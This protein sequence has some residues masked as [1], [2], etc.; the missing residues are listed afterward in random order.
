MLSSLNKARNLLQWTAQPLVG[1][2]F[3]VEGGFA[4]PVQSAKGL[5]SPMPCRI[6]VPGVGLHLRPTCLK[7]LARRVWFSKTR[8]GFA[9]AFMNQKQ[10][11]TN[12]MPEGKRLQNAP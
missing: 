12:T 7:C 5:A 3:A 4:K 6:V 1:V 8:L 10:G 9:N 2:P 11:F